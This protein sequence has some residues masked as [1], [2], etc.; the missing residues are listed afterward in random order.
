MGKSIHFLFR[1]KVSI[2]P[3]KKVS[4]PKSIVRGRNTLIRGDTNLV[5]WML[6][7]KSAAIHEIDDSLIHNI[8]KLMNFAFFFFCP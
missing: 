5:W 7:N 3:I 8:H 1:I 4:N 2:V 6:I